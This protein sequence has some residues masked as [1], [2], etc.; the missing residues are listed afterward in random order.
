MFNKNLIEY[1]KTFFKGRKFLYDIFIFPLSLLRYVFKRKKIYKS[2]IE[3][4][5]HWKKALI[6]DNGNNWRGGRESLIKSDNE[7]YIRHILK[8]NSKKYN[9]I[10]DIGSYDG[11]FF[12]SYSSFNQIICADMFKE[13]EEVIKNKYD[14]KF[15]FVLLNGNDF[16]NIKSNSI[17]FVFSIHTLQRV[18]RNILI[19][20]FNDI[21][22]ITSKNSYVFLQVPD[23]YYYNSL[24]HNFTFISALKLKKLLPSFETTIDYTI[25]T[26]SPIIIGKKNVN[27]SQSP[28]GK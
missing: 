10:L 21:D 26:I 15:D 22:R 9:T 16:S 25:S 24:N 19:K 6:N 13:S 11:Y 28:K 2:S 27:V 17:D 18:P 14:N 1:L 23:C 7:N 5:R 8:K 3:L 20:Y 4:G 12:D